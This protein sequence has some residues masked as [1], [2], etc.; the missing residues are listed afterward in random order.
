MNDIIPVHLQSVAA[1]SYAARVDCDTLCS[2]CGKMNRKDQRVVTVH[3]WDTQGLKICT[4][5]TQCA[6]HLLDKAIAKKEAVLADFKRRRLE[7]S[8]E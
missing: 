5:H 1:A 8:Y 6:V 3:A 2:E 7:L 4:L